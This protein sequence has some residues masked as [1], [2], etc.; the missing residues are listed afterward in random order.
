MVQFLWM[1]VWQL[2]AKLSILLLYNPVIVLLGVYSN[3]LKAYVQTKTWPWMFMAALFIIAETWKQ[4]RCPSVSEWI[5]KLWYIQ[6]V[7]YY[8][9]QFYPKDMS[10]QAMKRHGENFSVYYEV[11][12]ANLKRQHTI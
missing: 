3:E 5:D 4:P 2:I 12:E 9:Q 11:K 1:T 7:D 10:Y 6:T 8:S